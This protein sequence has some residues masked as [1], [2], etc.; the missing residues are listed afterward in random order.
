M[1]RPLVP[2]DR[3]WSDTL[4]SEHFGSSRIVTR[5]RVHDAA[6]LPGFVAIGG[7]APVGLLQ[8]RIDEGECE[9]LVLVVEQPRK[10][11]GTALLARVRDTA[12]TAGCSRLWLVTTNDNVA[13]RSLYEALGWRLVAVRKDAV[14]RSRLLKP[15]IPERNAAGVAIEDELEY[16]IDVASE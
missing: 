10:G 9:I 8:F 13:A 5:G 7:D 12:R 11:I 16:E 1:I 14:N 2:S 4:V 6:A 3:Q 15:E